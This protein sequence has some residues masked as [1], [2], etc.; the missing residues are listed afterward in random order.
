MYASSGGY[1]FVVG[2][3]GPPQSTPQVNLKLPLYI[4]AGICAINILYIT[5]FLPESLPPAKR[6]HDAGLHVSQLV[7]LY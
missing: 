7:V 1:S 4:A 2:S 5:T 3:I 6:R